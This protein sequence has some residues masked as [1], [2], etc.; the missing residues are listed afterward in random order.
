MSQ[1]SLLQCAL[2]PLR[3]DP[4]ELIAIILL[5]AGVIEQLQK[6]LAEL[7]QQVKDSHDRHDGL[8]AKVAGLE[9]KAAR[10]GGFG[11]TMRREALQALQCG[12]R[13]A[14]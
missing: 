13:L 9:K 10:P 1:A 5:Q 2:D 3:D 4:E 6:E 14:S 12:S 7:K 8:L 11:S